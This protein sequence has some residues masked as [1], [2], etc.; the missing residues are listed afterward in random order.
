[1]GN[2]TS[3][4][5]KSVLRQ[6]QQ[7]KASDLYWACRASDL[8]S[9]RELIA[10]SDYTDLNRLEPNGSTALHVASHF[11]HTKIVRVLLHQ[12]G[13]MRHRRNRHGL[14][15]YKESAND[16][17]HQLFHRSANSHRFSSDNTDDAQQLFAPIGVEEV[18]DEEQSNDQ[19]LNDWV[20]GRSGEDEIRLAKLGTKFFK[21]CAASVIL[22]PI[23]KAILENKA[24]PDDVRNES[25]AA[26]ALKRPIDEY[27]TPKHPEYK[28]ASELVSK[29]AKTKD[30]DHL[31]R[32]YTL[33]TPFYKSLR[34]DA[35]R[36]RLLF[37]LLFIL[38]SLQKRAYKGHTFRGLAMTPKDLRAYR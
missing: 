28:K 7:G 38:D 32:L 17:I 21:K 36:S 5:E 6:P 13:V 14:T 16:E 2:E 33:G 30:V 19:V 4:E 25:T 23:F 26:E 35:Q 9:V 10:S 3:K 8:D 27:V 20:E 18:E 34:S 31:V 22:R 11:G 37:P 15:A 1:M 12:H 29:Y 24:D